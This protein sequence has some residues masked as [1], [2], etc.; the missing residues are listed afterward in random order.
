MSTYLVHNQHM[1]I[2]FWRVLMSNLRRGQSD[3]NSTKHGGAPTKLTAKIHR[4][5]V[6]SVRNGNYVGTAAKAAGVARSTVSAWKRKADSG[7]EPYARLFAEIEAVSAKA[8]EE[9]VSELRSNPDWRA[10]AWWLEHGPMREAWRTDSA[11]QATEL[12]VALLDQLRTRSVAQQAEQPM[13]EEA[14]YTDDD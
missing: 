12:A 14:S 10:K 4:A 13:L 5:I 8:E 2:L 9:T 6:A 3:L 1:R 11:G 7:I